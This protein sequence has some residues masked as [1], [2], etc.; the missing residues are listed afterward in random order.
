[1]YVVFQMWACSKGH[2]DTALVLYQWN[3]TALKVLN[4][5]EQTALEC[6][7]QGPLPAIAGEIERLEASRE[8]AAV[9]PAQSTSSPGR[10]GRKP[11]PVMPPT[12]PATSPQQ[13]S[14]DGVFLRP[15]VVTR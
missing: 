3:H 10:S 13:P 15:G 8:G 9:V 4:Q 2:R 6:A 11:S 1:M 7:L 12:S 5:L 14:S